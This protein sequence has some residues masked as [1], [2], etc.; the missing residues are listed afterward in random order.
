MVGGCPLRELRASQSVVIPAGVEEIGDDW[1]KNS[2]TENVTVSASVRRLGK[3][4]FQNCGQLRR[5]VFSESS[6]LESVGGE[7]F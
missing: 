7:C 4:A 3:G 5:V 6:A 2:A 1:F